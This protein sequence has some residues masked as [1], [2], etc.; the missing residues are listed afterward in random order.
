MEQFAQI[1]FTTTRDN[2]FAVQCDLLTWVRFSAT[3]LHAPF[4][5]V[6]SLSDE[7]TGL[8]I[9]QIS[10]PPG[11]SVERR[12]SRAVLYQLSGHLQKQDKTKSKL[13]INNV[14]HVSF[15]TF[16]LFLKRNTDTD[17]SGLKVC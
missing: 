1:Y 17:I 10:R 15:G 6:S 11:F 2:V 16:C 4:S 5:F 14:R 13:K 9:H 3:Y 12:R 7:E 8:E